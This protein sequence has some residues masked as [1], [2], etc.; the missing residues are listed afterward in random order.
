[1]ISSGVGIGAGKQLSVNGDIFI[2]RKA[3][4]TLGFFDIFLKW[5]VVHS[6]SPRFFAH[7]INPSLPTKNTKRC[8]PAKV[9]YHELSYQRAQDKRRR[10]SAVLRLRKPRSHHWTGGVG[11]RTTRDGTAQKR[12][13]KTQWR[14]TF[15]RQDLLRRMRNKARFKSLAFQR[16]I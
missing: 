5:I 2:R 13:R 15:L 8:A 9:L 4:G 14:E 1:M 7:A 16:Q 6:I 11:T 10:N 12:K 3:E